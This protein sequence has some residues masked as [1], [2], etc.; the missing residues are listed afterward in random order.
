M[1][2]PT[3]TMSRFPERNT[4]TSATLRLR[5]A[6]F[7]PCARIRLQL[8]HDSHAASIDGLRLESRCGSERKHR[9][10]FRKHL[11]R[12]PL[13]S[14]R[15]AIVDQLGKECGAEA[16]P[17]EIRADQDGEL[18]CDVVRVCMGPHYPQR[19]RNARF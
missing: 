8:E 7:G 11:A 17:L 6:L 9:P 2:H 4:T 19:L 3:S 16:V 10:V 15:P 13:S 5:A 18:R 14:A 12:E 1:E